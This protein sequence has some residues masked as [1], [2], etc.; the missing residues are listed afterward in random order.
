MVGSPTNPAP[1]LP[2]L[3]RRAERGTPAPSFRRLAIRICHGSGTTPP[4][5]PGSRRLSGGGHRQPGESPATCQQHRGSS[6]GNRIMSTGYTFHPACLAFP[7]LPKQNSNRSPTTSGRGGCCTG[8]SATGFKSSTGA[9][10][11]PP[12]TGPACNPTSENGTA[13]V[14]RPSGLSPRTWSAAT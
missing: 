9:T 1:L 7:L 3:L 8:L 2:A 14:R 5:V 12:V 4:A 13:P 6:T 10:G 11:S